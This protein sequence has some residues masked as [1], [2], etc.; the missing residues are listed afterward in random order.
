MR[1]AGIGGKRLP[2]K[3]GSLI[4]RAALGAGETQQLKDSRIL[5]M[6]PMEAH[7]QDLRFLCPTLPM[8]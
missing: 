5:R 6:R 3:A 1:L 4:Q 2:E 8:K 7:Q